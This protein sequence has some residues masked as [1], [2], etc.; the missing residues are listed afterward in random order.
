MPDSR[1][2]WARRIQLEALWRS[3]VRE[4]R[5]RYTTAAGRTWAVLEEWEQSLLP[6]PDGAFIVR[7]SAELE[8]TALSEYVR[9][10][11]VFT[12]L[13]AHGKVPPPE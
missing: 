12:E 3:R 4:A 1:S 10:L 5:E 13:V 8:A 2:S 9:V 11:K 6:S 7:R